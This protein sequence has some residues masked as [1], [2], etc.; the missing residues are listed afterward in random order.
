MQ[1]IINSIKNAVIEIKNTIQ[2]ADTSY[3]EDKNATGD[4]QLKLD[5]LSDKIIQ[6]HLIKLPNLKYIVSEE[7]EKEIMI[8]KDKDIIIAYDPLDGSS[9]VDSN[10][11]IGSI[12]GIYKNT[13]SGNNLICAIYS[14][15]GPRLELVISNPTPKLYRHDGK[16]F[17]FIKD[18]FLEEKGKLNASGATQKNWQNYHASFIKKLFDD[19]YRLRYSGAMVADLHQILIKKGGLFSYPATSDNPKGKL[20]LAFE[21][22]PFAFIYKNAGG[23]AID[24]KNEL[25][26]IKVQKPHDTSACFFG[27]NKEINELK[28]WYEKYGK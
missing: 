28:K 4:T 6:K 11:S 7:Q 26:D 21:V 16:N 25:L 8:H 5:I 24:G 10:L 22:L 12:F 1:E 17:I 18:L 9:L 2:T 13:I 20:R 23:G 19:G 3:S 27:S 15:Y 14:V